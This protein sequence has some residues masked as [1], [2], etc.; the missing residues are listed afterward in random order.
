MRER[1]IGGHLVLL[2]LAA[3][4]PVSCTSGREKEGDSSAPSAD[5]GGDTDSGGGA[6][7]SGDTSGGETGEETAL[8]V[9][10]IEVD[11]GGLYAESEAG[12]SRPIGGPYAAGTQGLAEVAPGS[13]WITAYD[14]GMT[15]CNRSET[16]PLAAGDRLEW[17]VSDLPGTFDT[18]GYCILP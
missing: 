17:T 12:E 11:L 10:R 15:A 18:A 8:L 16:A 4:S 3:S 6:T 2:L 7:D 9:I 1:S 5:T 13:W 14:T